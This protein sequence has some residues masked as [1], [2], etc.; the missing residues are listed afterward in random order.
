MTQEGYGQAFQNGFVR[1][2][3]F[4]RSRGA[5]ADTAED[6]AQAAWVRGWERLNQL[7]DEGMVVSWVNTIAV[8]VHRRTI[9]Y[10]ARYEPLP[11]LCGQAGIDLAAIDA[12]T[13]LT[14]CRPRDRILLEQQMGGLTTEEI[15]G[16][17]GVSPTAIRIR[18]VRARRAARASVEGRGG[19]TSGV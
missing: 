3:R 11:E 16:K 15:A 7:R 4:L 18:L 14:L 8:N 6:A 9:Q 13:I 10:E 12:A 17:H 19:Q 1:T 2:V 5:S